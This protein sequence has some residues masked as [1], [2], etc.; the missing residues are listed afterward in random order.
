[1]IGQ[2]EV[3]N[4]V[5]TSATPGGQNL[6]VTELLPLNSQLTVTPLA[7]LVNPIAELEPSNWRLSV[8]DPSLPADTRFLHVFQGTDA[9]VTPASATLIQSMAGNLMDGAAFGNTAVWFVHDTTVPFTGTAYIVPVSV[10]QHYVAG[11]TPGASYSVVSA[12]TSAGLGVT[13][14]PAASGVAADS[15][16]V[17]VLGF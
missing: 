16:G 9:G 4:N 7:S 1:L 15:A 2:P 12:V 17:L 14:M 11:L 13:I 10:T 3:T 8:E 5:I 6:T